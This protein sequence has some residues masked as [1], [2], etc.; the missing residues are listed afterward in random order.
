V[1]RKTKNKIGETTVRQLLLLFFGFFQVLSL[2]AAENA[3]IPAWMYIHD[4]NSQAAWQTSIHYKKGI[5]CIACHGSGDEPLASLQ[6][7][8]PQPW[9]TE[10][11]KNSKPGK[12]SHYDKLCI[13]CHDNARK[14]F[15]Q[16]FH[17]KHASLGKKNIPTCSYCHVGHESSITAQTNALN[18]DTLGR[19]CAG[20]HG[21]SSANE[22]Q[23][24]AVNLTGPIWS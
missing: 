14:N 12:R 23:V 22:R 20:C 9:D 4:N 21:G 11:L 15:H 2:A 13:R 24:M 19:V 7:E 5:T 18:P 1:A 6:K 16:T 17:G 8:S 10:I 3:E